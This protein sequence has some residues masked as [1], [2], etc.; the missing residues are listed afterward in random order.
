[1]GHPL[2]RIMGKQGEE[3]ENLVLEAKNQVNWKYSS[4][5]VCALLILKTKIVKNKYEYLKW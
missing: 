2:G 3:T 5:S 1:M 4:I